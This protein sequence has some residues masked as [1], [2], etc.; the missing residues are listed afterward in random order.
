MATT[1]GSISLD[2][3]TWARIDELVESGAYDSRSGFLQEAAQ[4]KIDEE[5]S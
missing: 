5:H 4:D 1:S 3:M 2:S